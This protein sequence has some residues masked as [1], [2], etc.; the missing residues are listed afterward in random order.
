M[1]EDLCLGQH[2]AR[3]E[4]E[5][6]KEVELGRG[7][8]DGTACPTHF[9]GALVQ[10]EVGEAEDSVV[11]GLVPRAPENGMHPGDHL[12]EGEGLGDVVVATDGQT[13]QFVLEGVL[14]R[15]EQHRHPDTVGAQ[16]TGHLEPVEVGQHDV[17]DHQVRRVLLGL[18]QR[19]AARRR[20]VHGEP[21][22]TQRGGHRIDDRR[23]IV[24]DEDA[25]F[26]LGLH[27]SYLPGV[28]RPTTDSWSSVTLL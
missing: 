27:R 8:A 17:E 18:G 20:L 10:L 28:Q 11:L 13:G 22:V 2:V 15:E 24:D 1:I 23:L 7:E 19:L 3:V 12:G 6:A 16:A 4:H 14:G 26:V 5:I 9:V 25:C 21:L